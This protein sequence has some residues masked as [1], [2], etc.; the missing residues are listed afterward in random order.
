[1]QRAAS[2]RAGLR[3]R[4]ASPI[5]AERR[6]HH[7]DFRILAVDDDVQIR[8]VLRATLT[9]ARYAVDT[10]ASGEEALEMMKDRKYHLVLLDLS[11]PGVDGIELCR[12]LRATSDADI[13]IVSVRSFEK[14]IV[15]GLDAGA[16]DYITKPF[17]MPELLARIRSAL[18]RNVASM[19]SAP[20]KVSLAGVEI[21]FRERRVIVDGK[22]V[23]LT[24]KEFE[25]LHYLANH[26]DKPIPHREILSAVWGPEHSE[27]YE[28]LRA[29]IKQL[30]KKIEPEPSKPKYLITEPW[31]GYKLRLS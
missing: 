15:A 1:M 16:D 27:H 26:P 25:V 7:V 29:F 24:P 11:M 10:A 12:T 5:H 9:A 8:R 31:V 22:D 19:D 18:R 30:R 28:Y 6:I 2:P 14:D 13:I 4:Q 23:R 20:H 3:A 21:D 17:R